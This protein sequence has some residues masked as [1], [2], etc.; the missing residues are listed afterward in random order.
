VKLGKI[1]AIAAAIVVP[2][3]LVVLSIWY[4]NKRSVNSA[5][6]NQKN[7][8]KQRESLRLSPYRDDNASTTAI[9]YSIGYGHQ[10][11][12]ADA[13]MMNGITEAQADDIFNR[14]AEKIEIA[15]AKSVTVPLNQNQFDAL[16]DFTYNVGIDAFYHSTLL[17]KINSNAGADEIRAEFERWIYAGNVFNQGL[18]DRR[19]EEI[20][21]YFA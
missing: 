13:W 7:R 15:I 5:S 6:N 14:D 2:G 1:L 9:E 10:I 17:K 16:W 19:T 11:Q 20:N 8:T 18:K 4:L 3:G 12:S 21:T